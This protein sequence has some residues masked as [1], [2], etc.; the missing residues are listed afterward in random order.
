MAAAT[1]SCTEGRAFT[2][3]EAMYSIGSGIG[4]IRT[5]R[6]RAHRTGRETFAATG[7]PGGEESWQRWSAQPWPEGD[8]LF[9]AGIATGLAMHQAVRQAGVVDRH[10]GG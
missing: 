10:G 5:Q 1:T 9:G 3:A 7:A 2:T 4:A 8:R 6:N